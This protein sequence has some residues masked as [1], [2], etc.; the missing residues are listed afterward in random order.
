MAEFDVTR[1]LAEAASYHDEKRQRAQ[2]DIRQELTRLGAEARRLEG[3]LAAS[4]ARDE[5][6]TELLRAEVKRSVTAEAERERWQAEAE[7]L[8][9]LPCEPL[10]TGIPWAS[11]QHDTEPDGSG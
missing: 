4:V 10:P 3:L 5:V 6:A 7:R 8:A 2:A 9:A 11:T 1:A